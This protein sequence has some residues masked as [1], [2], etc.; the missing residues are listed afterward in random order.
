MS[1]QSPRSMIDR[2]SCK[3]EVD[4][5]FSSV[6]ITSFNKISQATLPERITNYSKEKHVSWF[7]MRHQSVKK[8]WKVKTLHVHIGHNAKPKPKLAT[9]GQNP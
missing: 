3:A 5:L 6:E 9:V 8:T 1:I 4:L 7:T 2:V